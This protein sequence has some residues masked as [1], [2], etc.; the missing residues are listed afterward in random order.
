[1]ENTSED[2]GERDKTIRK[3]RKN[4]R[5]SDMEPEDSSDSD[6]NSPKKKARR[7]TDL[8]DS[9]HI[10]IGK[11]NSSDDDGARGEMFHQ[12]RFHHRQR[13]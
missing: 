4:L 11:G 13:I 1:M 10:T 12:M 6:D 2:E 7:R 9:K 3:N 8:A 5:D